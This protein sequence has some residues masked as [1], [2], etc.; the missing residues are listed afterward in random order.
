MEF[1]VYGPLRAATGGKHVAV[2]V[3]GDTVRDAVEALLA[4]HPR[5]EPHLLDPAG[6]L[7]PSVRVMRDGERVDLDAPCP[8]GATLSLFPAMQGG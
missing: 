6:A 5:A 2:A 8:P 4:A 3:A 7:R 1:V